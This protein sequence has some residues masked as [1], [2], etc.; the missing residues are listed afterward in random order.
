MTRVVLSPQGFA[1]AVRDLSHTFLDGSRTFPYVVAAARAWTAVGLALLVSERFRSVARDAAPGTNADAGWGGARL[2]DRHPHGGPGAAAGHGDAVASTLLHVRISAPHGD[3][4]ATGSFLALLIPIAVGVWRDT[5]GS[6]AWP[7]GAALGLMLPALWMTGS[8]TAVAAGVR[9]RGGRADPALARQLLAT[10]AGRLGRPGGGRA[11]RRG[12]S[13]SGL[14]SRQHF[15]GCSHPRGNG[16][17]R[18][19]DVANR[20][21]P[22]RRHRPVP[23]SL[24]RL[25]QKRVQCSSCPAARTPTTIFSRCWPSWDC[26]ARLPLRWSSSS[27]S[28][29]NHPPV[30]WPASSS[31]C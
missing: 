7:A 1:D 9:G 20:S 6:L 24:E 18:D 23:R 16:P 5:A 13:Q 2:P 26:W 17:R 3:V 28:A 25:H 22:R 30:Y 14:R 8:R 31:S 4:N 29:L 19:P 10:G 15:R 21:A 11:R 27:R 12:V